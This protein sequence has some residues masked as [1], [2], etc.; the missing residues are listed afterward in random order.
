MTPFH[1]QN[2]IQSGKMR[3]EVRDTPSFISHHPFLCT[4]LIQGIH[5]E[6]ALPVVSPLSP[7]KTLTLWSY[8]WAFPG[9]I[10]KISLCRLSHC[11]YSCCPENP[12][13]NSCIQHSSDHLPPSLSYTTMAEIRKLASAHYWLFLFQWSLIGTQIHP[14]LKTGFDRATH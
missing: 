6:Q 5:P 11:Y 7:Q 4:Q 13:P 9:V 14:W 2:L 12:I 1:F 3:I 10:V 8:W